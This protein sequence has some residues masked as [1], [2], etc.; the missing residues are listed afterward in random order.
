MVLTFTVL[1]YPVILIGIGIWRARSLKSHADFMVASRSLPAWVLVGSLVCTWVGAGTL[2]GGAGLAYRNGLSALWF[3]IGA[4]FGLIGVYYL[5][6]KVRRLAQY[7]VP[8]ILEKRYNATA[9]VLGTIAIIMSYIT[10]A[11]YQ[12]RGG[13]WILSIVTDGALS[14][15]TGMYI[16]SA[17]I[18]TFTAV[19]GMVSIVSVDVVNGVVITLS[20]VIALPYLILTGG[21]PDVLLG[22]LPPEMLTPMGGHNILWVLGVAMPTFLLL[23][24]ESGMY[25][26]FFSARDAR[27]AR[28]AVVGMVLG[29]MTIETCIALMAM[30]GR[31]LY[32]DLMAETSVLGRAASETIILY[33]AKNALP[34]GLGAAL[35]AA[36]VAIVV[37]SGSTMLLVSSTN[38]SRD[39]FERFIQPNASD[40]RKLAVQR[41]S[42]LAFGVI[43]LFLLT[44]FETVLSMALYAYSVVGATLTPVLVAAFTWKRVTPQGAVACLAGGLTTIVSLATMDSMGISFAIEFGGSIFDFASSDYIVIPG[45]IVSV[46]CLVGVSLATKP[47]PEDVWGPFFSVK[48]NLD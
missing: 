2:F 35:L 37:S 34:L 43:G 1:L 12:F 22:T 38:V 26:K 33:L 48:P 15:E 10:I 14:P 9:R 39:I 29:I 41:G 42:I 40:K 6:P 19:A 31:S 5:A 36:A 27:S 21:G 25:Q 3:S 45:V 18:I 7:T 11:A 13:G 47:S 23:F 20:V 28:R 30:I 32:P 17:T 46:C 24:G 16:T 4:W 8:D 44:Q